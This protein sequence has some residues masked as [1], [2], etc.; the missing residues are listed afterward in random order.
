MNKRQ[1]RR[2]VARASAATMVAGMAATIGMGAASAA[3]GSVDWTEKYVASYHLQRTISNTT[4]SPGDVITVQTRFYNPAVDWYI[5]NVQDVH[6]PCLTY[7]EG[8]AK[9][10]GVAPKQVDPKNPD[11]D[12]P[13]TAYVF[14][15]LTTGI[16]KNRVG[17]GSK[18]GKT[19]EVKYTV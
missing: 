16:G 7:V 17:I 1:L 11:P 5:Q 9:F 15:K 19:F 18:T 6:N 12:Y 8:S 14:S 2:L 3:P 4:P 13:D 10:D